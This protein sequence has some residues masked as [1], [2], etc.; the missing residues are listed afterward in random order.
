LPALKTAVVESA[1]ANEHELK[2]ESGSK[3]EGI[4]GVGY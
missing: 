3:E 4:G 1:E 2:L